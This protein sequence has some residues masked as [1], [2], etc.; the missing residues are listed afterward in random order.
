MI[1]TKDII[2]ALE[3]ARVN[4]RLLQGHMTLLRMVSE[5]IEYERQVAELDEL[6]L[7]L[8]EGPDEG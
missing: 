3:A 5:Q 7:Q 6:L 1:R 4:A 8:K 2:Q